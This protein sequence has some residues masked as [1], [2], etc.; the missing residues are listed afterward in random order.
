[1]QPTQVQ[2]E[3]TH[4]PT[5]Q[6]QSAP[7]ASSAPVTMT[8]DGAQQAPAAANPST[9]VPAAPDVVVAAPGTLG[10]ETN[11]GGIDLLGDFDWTKEF[12]LTEQGAMDAVQQ[13]RQTLQTQ[14]QPPQPAPVVPPAPV[15]QPAPQQQQ[16]QPAVPAFLPVPTQPQPQAPAPAA[17]QS[18]VP[19]QPPI[20]EDKV[21]GK[22][23]LATNGD[24]VAANAVAIYNLRREEGSPIS[25]ADAESLARQVLGRTAPATPAGPAA[26]G[27]PSPAAPTQ[28]QSAPAPATGELAAILADIE[29]TKE[30]LKAAMNV[31]GPDY[32]PDAVADLQVKLGELGLQKAMAETAQKQTA[33]SEAEF[34]RDWERSFTEATTQF[35]ELADPRSALHVLAIG[36]QQTAALDPSHPDYQ[37]AGR[38]DAALYFAQ[39]AATSLGRTAPAAP[40]APAP[41]TVPVSTPNVP[42]FQQPQPSTPLAG[43][44]G[45]GSAPPSAPQPGADLSAQVAD[46]GAQDWNNLAHFYANG[47]L[48]V[49]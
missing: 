37:H 12:N 40:A 34:Q 23:R 9:H 11:P 31:M 5:A 38:S 13:V 25:L 8:G 17:P 21:P 6:V 27:D 33:A 46:L 35:P 1:M 28:Q 10:V 26:P 47:Q 36:L 14:P 42:A 39:K 44:F 2:S 18:S 43:I 16:Q 29:A 3:V 22:I 24:P 49:R 4:S 7:P 15:Q 30:S 41:A 45:G 32:A 48:A 19:A 20:Q